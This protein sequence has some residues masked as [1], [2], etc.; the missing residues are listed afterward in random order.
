MGGKSPRAMESNKPESG[1]THHD[2]AL[3]QSG[4]EEEQRKLEVKKPADED[5]DSPP[6]SNPAQPPSSDALGG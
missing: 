4:L 2:E 1:G 5:K 3:E 6:P